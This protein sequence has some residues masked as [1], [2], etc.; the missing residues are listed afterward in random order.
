MSGLFNVLDPVKVLRN[1]QK[2]IDKRGSIGDIDSRFPGI[3]DG[4]GVYIFSIRASR[5][6]TPIYVGKAQKTN[7]RQECLN[8]NNQTSIN[9]YLLQN[10]SKGTLTLWLLEYSGN[11]RYHPGKQFIEDCEKQLIRVASLKNPN[12]I[13]QH[14]TQSWSIDGLHRNFRLPRS[15]K[16]SN[17]L[18]KF[19]NMMGMWKA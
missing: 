9:Q 13:N 7:F 16:S 19:V 11:G 18:N 3:L 8:A 5:G 15:N 2:L 1:E 10:V 12:I 4:R 6:F 17:Q 14:H